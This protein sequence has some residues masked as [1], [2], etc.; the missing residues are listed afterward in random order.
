[1]A[2][3]GRPGWAQRVMR[4]SCASVPSLQHLAGQPAGAAAVYQVPAVSSS[5]SVCRR[6]LAPTIEACRLCCIGPFAALLLAVG[7][8]VRMSY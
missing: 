6:L 8:L 4:R 2:L 5:F 7:L 1:M 3:Y